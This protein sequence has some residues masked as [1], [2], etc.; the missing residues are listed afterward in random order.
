MRTLRRTLLSKGIFGPFS[1]NS[2][3]TGT[4]IR[5]IGWSPMTTEPR[6]RCIL[7][8]EDNS[9]VRLFMVGQLREQGY[10]VFEAANGE[11]AIAL[12]AVEHPPWIGTLFTDIQLGGELSGW[13]VAEAFREADPKIQVIYASGRYQDGERR[14][15]DSTFFTKPY[16]PG[17]IFDAIEHAPA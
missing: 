10:A 12:L 3:C 9:M 14:V 11:D 8:V 15:S 6:K 4:Y 1:N 16:I 17:D 5:A 2:R 7:I 13:D